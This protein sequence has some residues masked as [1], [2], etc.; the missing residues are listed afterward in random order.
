MPVYIIFRKYQIQAVNPTEATKKLLA[1]LDAKTD[2]D[3]H[4]ADSIREADEQ[5]STSKLAGWTN[6]AKKQLF[7]K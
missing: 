7:G 6:S 2:E 4:I 3:Y 5:P 1:A